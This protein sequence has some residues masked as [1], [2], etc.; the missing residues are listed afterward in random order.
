MRTS[1]TPPLQ[2]AV[3][4]RRRL[5]PQHR[6]RRTEGDDDAPP[7]PALELIWCEQ[8]ELRAG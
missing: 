5:H 7:E 1:P 6:H 4:P 2:S 3:R 8:I